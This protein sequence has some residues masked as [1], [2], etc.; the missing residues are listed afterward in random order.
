MAYEYGSS[1]QRLDFPNPYRIE[2]VFRMVAA[3]IL[4]GGALYALL[5]ARHGL[6]A[7]LNGWS[8]APIV[9]GVG[10]LAGGIKHAATALGRLRFFFGR[11]KPAGLAGELA[12]GE[13]GEKSN[14]P[15]LKATM[16]GGAIAVEEPTGPLNGLLYS[17]VR[18]LIWA[19]QPIQWVAQL[20]FRTGLTLAVVLLALLVTLFGTSGAHDLAW[21]GLFFFVYTA[22]LLL[23]PLERGAQVRTRLGMGGLIGLVLVAILAPVLIHNVSPHLG[24]LGGIDLSGQALLLLVCAIAA[25]LVFFVA[26][27]RQMVA[28]PETVMACEIATVSMNAPPNQILVELDREMQRGWVE[29]MPNRR[30]ARQVP[31]TL[32]ASGSFNGELLEETQPMPRDDMRKITLQDALGEPRYRWLTLLSGLGVLFTL[33]CTIALLM[34]AHRVAGEDTDPKIWQYICFAG[35]MFSLATF[36][37]RAGHILWSRFDF[38]SRLTWVEIEGNFQRSNTAIGAQFTDRVRTEKEII[39]VND[40][41]MRV[42]VAEVDSVTFGADSLRRMIGLRGRPDLAQS[43]RLHLQTFAEGQSSVDMPQSRVDVEKIAAMNAMNRASGQADTRAAL[44]GAV[45]ALVAPEP[46][47]PRPTAC[48]RCHHPVGATAK[49]CGECGAALG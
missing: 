31:L 16:R 35:G 37:L 10:M 40:M 47:R 38:T 29:Q 25:V 19:P 9:V 2:N 41:T 14:A 18:P 26:L 11:G 48:P 21:L 12:D 27:L 39:S 28:P 1:A 15:A 5:L 17:L 43:L 46:P 7:H 3:V 36:C 6:S 44:Q 32:G 13:T 42:W 30:Y 33:A 34:F 45:D 23:I 8:L 4:I 20:Q 49:F 22:V 24:S